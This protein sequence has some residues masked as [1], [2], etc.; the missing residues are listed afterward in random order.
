MSQSVNP[1]SRGRIE[2]IDMARAVALFAMAIYHFAWDLEF[3]NY[4]ERGLTGSGGWKIF[5][6]TIASS[7]LFLVGVSLVLAHGRAIRWRPFLIRLAQVVAGAVAITVVTFFVT[8]NSFVFFGILQLIA[9]ASLLGLLFIRLPWLV[10]AFAAIA[11]VA[12]PFVISHPV[13]DPKWFA[14]IGFYQIPP[15]SNDF[16]PIFPFFGAVLAGI[17][18]ARFALAHSVFDRMRSWNPALRPMW[19]LGVLGRHAL[20]FYLLHQPILFGMVFVFSLAAP[21]DTQAVFRTDCQRACLA[22]RDGEFC[23]R[24]CGCAERE[25]RAQGLFDALMGGGPDETQMTRIRE[26]TNQC[27][28]EQTK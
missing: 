21:A 14:W 2:F 17:A 23:E 28:F 26:I 15:F 22:E 6:R 19:R 18:A 27:S 3:F 9:V 10:T 25:L 5:A 7:F 8:P 24:Y 11:T 1:T 12:L 13:F 4:V 20:L 16:I